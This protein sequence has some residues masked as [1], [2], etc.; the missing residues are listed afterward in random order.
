MEINIPKDYWA[1]EKSAIEF[2][3]NA[4]PDDIKQKIINF[5]KIDIQNLNDQ[6]LFD[7]INN[8]LYINDVFFSGTICRKINKGDFFF[9]VRKLKGI[10]MPFLNFT[11]ES[12]MWEP[13]SDILNTWGRLNKPKE[14]LLYTSAWDPDVAIREARIKDEQ[15]ALIKY[16]ANRIINVNVI[17]DDNFTINDTANARLCFDLINEFL[18][19]EFSKEVPNG[20]EYLYRVSE[21]IAKNEYDAPEELQDAWGYVSVQDKEKYNICFRPKIAHS[22]LNLHG[23]L[24]CTI[25]EKRRIIPSCFAYPDKYSKDIQYYPIGSEIQKEFFPEVIIS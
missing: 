18:N 9:R 25:D 10:E 1:A 16:S 20:K 15:F 21:M 17:G 6:E 22:V 5:K 23:A 11:K 7:A 8:V 19:D 13:P 14:S 3:N 12:D 2:Y 24:I 4:N